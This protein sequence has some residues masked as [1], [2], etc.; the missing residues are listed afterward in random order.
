[1]RNRRRNRSPP[2]SP[3]GAKA[4]SAATG[5]EPSAFAVTAASEMVTATLDGAPATYPDGSA[6]SASTTVSALSDSLSAAAVSARLPDDAP[7][8]TVTLFADSV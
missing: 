1:V 2:P 8:A 3:A 6:P 4:Q 7:A 5:Y